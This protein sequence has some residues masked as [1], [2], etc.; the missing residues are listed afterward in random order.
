MQVSVPAHGWRQVTFNPPG[1]DV[2]DECKPAEVFDLIADPDGTVFAYA[3]VVD[4]STQDSRIVLPVPIV[5]EDT[6][7]GR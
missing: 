1:G 6:D 5:Q 3:V 7:A 2:L 4:R